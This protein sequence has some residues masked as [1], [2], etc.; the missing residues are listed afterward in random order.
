MRPFCSF[1]R[2][3]SFFD[4]CDAHGVLLY[5][6]LQFGAKDNYTLPG[7]R[8]FDTVVPAELEHQISRTSHHPAIALWDGCNECALMT[9]GRPANRFAQLGMELVARLDRSR[10]I[11]P[12]SPASGWESGV[13]RLSTRPNGQ[14]LVVGVGAGTAR[15]A[16]AAFPWFAESH[17]PY[18][19]IWTAFRG[20]REY[21]SDTTMVV[22]TNSAAEDSCLGLC[23]I[24][25]NSAWGRGDI[26]HAFLAWA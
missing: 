16:L 5:A 23:G 12:S 14:P 4:A 9:P 6:D 17:G 20:R 26:G 7:G 13:D 25:A 19:G 22:A 3:D 18:A 10:P 21:I 24:H 11:W 2:P 1:S 8:N 15:P